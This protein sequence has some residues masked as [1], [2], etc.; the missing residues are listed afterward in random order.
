MITFS[1]DPKRAEHEMHAIIFYL[2][3]FGYID[4]DFDAAEKSFVREIIRKLIE[5]RAKVA[6]PDAAESVRAEIVGKF[7]KHFHEVFE[8][9]DQ[10]VKDLFTESV[11]ENEDPKAFVHSKLKVRCFEIFQ[12][13]DQKGQGELMRLID[14]LLMA[15]GVAHPA[16]V[17]FRSELAQLLEADVE[18]ELDDSSAG[19][20]DSARIAVAKPI[21]AGPSKIDHPFFKP[22]EFHFSRDPEALARQ[23]SAD[24]ALI[25]RALGVI[26]TQRRS[27]NGRLTGKKNIAELAGT[28]P[29][30][31]GHT[32]V[33]M[34]KPGTRTELTVLGDLHGCYS[35][36]KATVLQSRFFERV[37]AYRKDPKNVPYPLL[38]LLG[39]YIDRGRFSLNGVL[40]T[41]LQ[42]FV[43]APDHVVMLRGNHEYYVEVNGT[44][45]GGVKPA[46]AI[47]TLKPLLPVDVFRHY[48]TLFEQMPNVF[49]FDRFMFV[50]GGIPKDRL[51]KER[52]KDLSSLNDPDMRFQMMWSD[53][54]TADVIPADLQ[55]AAARFAFGRMQFRAFMQRLGTTTMVR[56]HEKIIEGFS[57]AYDDDLG[58]LVTVFSAGGKD[59][60]DLPT[61]S[62]YRDVT[63]MALTITHDGQEA[64]V[65]PWVPD[66]R[67]YNDP[68]RN[69]FFKVAPE[70]EHRT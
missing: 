21:D 43:T 70:I 55:D 29:F 35:I 22:F 40:R 66:W 68:E 63:P 39:D 64:R 5:H 14:T 13:F 27:G 36:L 51:I 17:Q 18:I 4:G 1:N 67:S 58:R 16:E 60:N 47:N 11:S 48:R 57:A 7:T 32:Y 26:E 2:V 44:M 62:T 15:D 30:L 65:V 53:P 49:L 33:R 25:D 41:V 46:E 52:W 10:N 54:S 8:G 6:M 34:P 12:S 38:V 19:T 61:E 28:E 45:Y 9:I 3:T 20:R 24:R 37:D 31:D 69:A 59:N 23:V 42:L 50:H 56:G